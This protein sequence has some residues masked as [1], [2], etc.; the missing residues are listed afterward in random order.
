MMTTLRILAVLA[1][2]I[3]LSAGA[4]AEPVKLRV[5]WS[6]TPGHPTPLMPLVPKYGPD[7]L[8]H[9]GKSYVVEPMFMG[10][11]GA[12]L[13]ALGSGDVDLASINPQAFVLGLMEAKLDIRAIGQQLSEG[14]PGFHGSSFWVR[15]DE[16]KT[17]ADLKGKIIG[18]SALGTNIDA[19]ARTMLARAGL[20]A[21][22]DYQFV[23]IRFTAQLA[24]LESKRVDAAI[25]LQPFNLI[26]KKNPAYKSLFSVADVIG[27]QETSSWIGKADFIVKNRAVLVD[28]LEDNIR[29][30]RWS[31]DPKTRQEALK[32]VAEVTKQPIEN[33][34]E[35]TF[36]EADFFRD[37]N[38]L[39][40]VAR[41][42]KNVDDLHALKILPMTAQVAD[43]ID[44]SLAKEA[45][46][47]IK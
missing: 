46:A 6:A 14:V 1:A 38:C 37:P 40:D 2:A 5:Q 32:L 44:N 30:R 36:T 8:L 31:Y 15:A 35:W 19:A 39:I 34:Q 25:L 23:E 24:A 26:A 43:K 27:A 22:K 21:G 18:V 12:A 29:M 28:F 3:L 7:V 4:S 16:V 41:F 47:R 13:T 17:I 11:G 20:E 33:F 9:Y 10:G 45:A 42:Q